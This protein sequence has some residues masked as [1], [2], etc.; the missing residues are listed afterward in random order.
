MDYPVRTPQQLAQVLKGVRKDRRLTQAEVA[1][2]MGSLQGK[3]SALETNPENVSVKRLFRLL[4][5]L[6]LELVMRDRQGASSPKSR[7]KLEW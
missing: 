5:V 1:A 6:R 7:R 3:V 2:Q 4:S